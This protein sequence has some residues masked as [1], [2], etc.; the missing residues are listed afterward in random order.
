MSASYASR[1]A[2][3]IEKIMEQNSTPWKLFVPNQK[4]Q[5]LL[6]QSAHC[7]GMQATLVALGINFENIQKVNTEW[8]SKNGMVPVLVGN[9]T[10][11]NIASGPQEIRKSLFDNGMI[12]H[13]DD[14][15]T[16][17][18]MRDLFKLIEIIEKVELYHSWVDPV[19]VLNVTKKR[20]T[21]LLDVQ[22][23]FKL[24][25]FKKRQ[26]NV[27]KYLQLH[28]WAT[29]EPKEVL[30]EF[31][32]VLSVFSDLLG[33]KSYLFGHRI[34]EIDCALFGHLYAILTT[35]YYG[36]FGPKLADTIHEFQNLVDLTSMIDREIF[37]N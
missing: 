15:S 9:N 32:D 11:R 27:V 33:N 18:E 3:T 1:S 4:S 10:A 36:T 8:M 20:Y 28:Q 5:Q 16:H 6:E 24:F 37:K 13:Q 14:E 25:V 35:K 2:S 12:L 19:T 22:N 30:K 23:I 26:N 21:K 17:I 7:I 29:L 31:R 34:S